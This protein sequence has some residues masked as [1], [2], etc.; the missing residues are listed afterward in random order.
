MRFNGFL[1][2]ASVLSATVACAPQ[3]DTAAVDTAAPA[4]STPMS[5]AAQPGSDEDKIA[6]AM[7]A[8]PDSIAQ[9]ATIRDW[10]ASEGG[11]FRQLR[12]G[13]NDWICYPTTPGPEAS[14]GEDPM[15]VDPV[16]ERWLEAM[17]A[18]RDPAV[19]RIGFS[20]MLQGDRGASNSDP[21]ATDTTAHDWVRV[22]PHMMVVAP[23]TLLARF[24][25]T[26]GP[27][28]WVMWQ[29]TPYAHVMIP[30]R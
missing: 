14:V 13:T 10:P 25:T 27:S 15:C 30:V 3:E 23:R 17:L 9:G 19:D 18:Q 7:S 26:P 11:E 5:R 4:A 2:G 6:N 21:A 20:Y 22:G 24:P 1:I 8:A 29:G 28:P 16:F 12:A